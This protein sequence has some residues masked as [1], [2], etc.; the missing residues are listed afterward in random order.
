MAHRFNKNNIRIILTIAWLIFLIQPQITFA[1]KAQKKFSAPPPGFEFLLEK[2][3]TEVDV[4]YGGRYIGSVMAAYSP[5][6]VEFQNPEKLSV[7]LPNVIDRARITK[8]LSGKMNSNQFAICRSKYERKCGQLTP[9]I[10]AVIFDES[11]YRVDVFIASNELTVQEVVINKFLPAPSS[12]VSLIHGLTAAYSSPE[13]VEDNYSING[14][15]LLAYNESRL[16]MFSNISNNNNLEIDV[17]A[18]ERDYAGLSYQAGLLQTNNQSSVFLPTLQITGA[19]FSSNLDTRNDLDFSEGSPLNIFLANRGRVEIYK[20]NRL[21]SS[22]IYEAGNQSLD[23]RSLPSGAYNVTIKIL[24]AGRLVKQEQRFYRK[25]SQMPPADQDLF[26]VE[27]GRMMRLIKDGA[28]PDAMDNYLLRGGYS[29]RIWDGLGLDGNI[30]I[31]DSDSMIETGIF[32][33][34]YSLDMDA[35]VAYSK[36]GDQGYFANINGRVKKLA[37]SVSARKVQISDMD[38]IIDDEVYF[39]GYESR[40]QSSI[41]LSHPLGNGRIGFESRINK[42][43]FNSVTTHTAGIDLPNYRFSYSSYFSSSIELSRGDNLWQ[44]LIRFSINF[45][46]RRWQS[47]LSHTEQ[48]FETDGNKD[49]RRRHSSADI[50]WNDND[51]LASDL[52][53]GF[54]IQKNDSQQQADIRTQWESRY[55][56]I[57][58]S[59]D[60]VALEHSTNVGYSAALSTSFVADSEGIVIGG[61]Q[62]DQSAVIIDIDSPVYQDSYFDVL[63]DGSRRAYAAPGKSTIVSLRPFETYNIKLHDNG[64]QL[65]SFDEREVGLTLYPGNVK[66]LHFKAVKVDIVFGRIVDAVGEPIKNAVIDGVEG[67]AIT[68]DIGFFQAEMDS[69]TK[70]IT[71]R[72]LT[73][74]CTVNIPAYTVKQQVARLGKLICE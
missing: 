39:L 60:Q 37:I 68:D 1:K 22:G 69:S 51:L 45:T 44:G 15:S 47:R 62:T 36:H 29:S 24:Q 6:E 5:G 42:N 71:V 17:L 23:T 66:R 56:R 4:F 65:L 38:R 73:T 72:T 55:G 20:D 59:V 34:A 3:T 9:E 43:R 54:N 61:S 74:N 48:K 14:N 67:L 25:S 11:R 57:G 64:S 16:R 18:F 70:T 28:F 32:Y 13:N 10:A 40:E 41:R 8:A 53:V 19:R 12:G 58:A 21:V 52:D 46:E 2:Q 35:S 63:V 7:L 50:N 26:F 30:A 33:L 49:L 31:T 27:A